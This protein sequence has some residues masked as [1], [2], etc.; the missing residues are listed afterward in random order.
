MAKLPVD[1]YQK[2]INFIHSQLR[3]SIKANYQPVMIMTLLINGNQTKKQISEVLWKE[4]NNT[5]NLSHY[6]GVPVYRVLVDNGVVTRK[7]DIFSLILQNYSETEKQSLLD[8][9]NSWI[10]RSTSFLKTG[11][12]PWEEAKPLYQK[13]AKEN[14]LKTQTEWQEY[15]KTHTIPDNLPANPSV[16]YSKENILKNE[17]KEK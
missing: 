5:R 6:L 17:K 13:I 9:L 2:M 12:L 8:E 15:A 16:V 7:G 11:F 14:N 4:N 1:T 3:A 10:E